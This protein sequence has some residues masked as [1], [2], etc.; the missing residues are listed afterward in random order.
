M[1]KQ[2]TIITFEYLYAH[3]DCNLKNKDK[4]IAKWG[5]CC[6]CKNR[7]ELHKHCCH[8]N[9]TNP[10]K[11]VCEET[12]NVYAC[13]SFHEVDGTRRMNLCGEH[14]CCELFQECDKEVLKADKNHIRHYEYKMQ[15][16][17]FNAS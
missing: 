17:Q 6:I 14:G 10:N 7:L 13:I 12:L 1:E 2:K 4:Q 5:C 8:S 11:C 15:V 3:G 16:R 9:R